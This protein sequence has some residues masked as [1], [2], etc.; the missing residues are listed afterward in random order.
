MADSVELTCRVHSCQIQIR[1]SLCQFS[2]NH[3]SHWSIISE[4]LSSLFRELIHAD[5]R[6]SPNR[7]RRNSFNGESLRDNLDYAKNQ[8]I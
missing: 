6:Q 7:V 5:S 4:G 1:H 2:F 8:E 3:M